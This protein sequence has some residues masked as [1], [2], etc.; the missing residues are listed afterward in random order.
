MFTPNVDK[1]QEP[2]HI[3]PGGSFALHL[4]TYSPP[5]G[6]ISDNIIHR[7][8]LLVKAVRW[9]ATEEVKVSFNTDVHAG[10]PEKYFS[11]SS[12]EFAVTDKMQTVSFTT[13]ATGKLVTLY[14]EVA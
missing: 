10:P 2:V 5:V 1:T 12:G 7:T 13:S 14:F 9:R 11:E 3:L 8:V 6:R 4:K